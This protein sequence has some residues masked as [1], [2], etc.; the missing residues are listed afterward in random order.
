MAVVIRPSLS[1]LIS[2][3]FYLAAA[4]FCAPSAGQPL[5]TVADLRYGVVLYEYYQDHYLSALSELMVAEARGGINGHGDNPRLL[6]GGISL[7]FGMERK[8]GEIFTELL[9]ENRPLEVRNSAWF[10]LGKL[11]YLRGD[12]AG[13]EASLN[14][15]SGDFE[16]KLVA[17]LASLQFNL[18]I[19][20]G[21]LD[22]A[23]QLLEAARESELEN[24]LPYLYYNLGAAY[25]RAKNYPTALQYYASL[26]QLP[27]MQQ[28][29]TGE[30]LLALNDK[31]LTAAGYSLM[32]QGDYAQA[33]ARFTQVRLNS[34]LS[35]RALLGYG[36]A[37][38]QKGD[39]VRALQ[40]WQALM[41]RSLVYASTQEA[42]LAV[43]YAYEQLGAR[44]EA[45]KAF[46]N[47]EAVFEKEIARIDGVLQALRNQA[48]LQALD[49]S[50][51]S[52][53]NWFA[54][55]DNTD[56]NP[57]LSYLTEL[58]ASNQFQGAVQELRDL[59]RL[60]KQVLHWQKKV[61]IYRMMLRE[62][63]LARDKKLQTIDRRRLLQSSERL[64]Q[65]RNKLANRIET[66]TAEN[67]YMAIAGEA[68]RSL[69][70][71]V[72]SAEAGIERLR[73]AGES[74]APYDESLRRFRGLLLWRAGEEFADG[75]WHN[76]RA[77]KQLDAAL[78]ELESHQGG[79]HHVIVDAPDIA[80]F[81]TRIDTAETRVKHQLVQVN[82]AVALAESALRR[83]VAAS[84]QQQ[85][86]R[87]QHYLAETR[88]S[89]ARLYDAALAER[90]P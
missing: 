61:D 77:L 25:S 66:I 21:D 47:A 17:E 15:I 83:Q 2:A 3:G 38:A 56:V 70:D 30:E 11:R 68:T 13:A 81:Q 71:R 40:P 37:A 74:T 24:W 89:V 10:Y 5:Q 12:W 67:D 20:R 62:R 57:H 22:R 59:L 84:I 6:E 19:Q 18:V 29:D 14:N 49:I 76:R 36:W 75:L 1:I 80:P 23:G 58:F 8:A 69:Y 53:R 28:A 50:P 35:G 33:L 60:Q 87:L 45:L 64:Q 43:P 51:Q 31:T 4:S 44:G 27:V 26:S 7:A 78:I 79:L 32:L 72:L 39:Y 34:P 63:E 52:N 16:R 86:A 82:R 41:G 48:V 46:L 65:K 54:V 9:D 73:R 88:L 85:R 42:V 55:E 90:K